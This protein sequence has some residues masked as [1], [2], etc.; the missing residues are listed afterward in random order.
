[1]AVYWCDPSPTGRAME[2]RA[3][4]P[5][6]DGTGVRIN[7]GSVGVVENVGQEDRLSIFDDDLSAF[8]AHCSPLPSAPPA[9]QWPLVFKVFLA[10]S[11][12]F[13]SCAC[14]RA[15]TTKFRENIN[16]FS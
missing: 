16:L 14:A 12:A 4:G 5:Q 9:V 10:F 1:M 7:P 11:T 8:C 15:Q 6:G 2:Y 3:V 13:S